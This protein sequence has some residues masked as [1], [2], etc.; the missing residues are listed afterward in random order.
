MCVFADVARCRLG[1][2]EV[3]PRHHISKGTLDLCAEEAHQITVGSGTWSR[4]LCKGVYVV[5]LRL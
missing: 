3:D 5:A 4:T 2:K 1:N